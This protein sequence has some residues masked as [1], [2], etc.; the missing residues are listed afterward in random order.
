MRF[1]PRPIQSLELRSGVPAQV[2]VLLLP[3]GTVFNETDTTS[4]R[5]DR[6]G[7]EVRSPDGVKSVLATHSLVDTNEDGH[8]AWRFISVK[9]CLNELPVGDHPSTTTKAHPK[10]TEHLPGNHGRAEGEADE[11][12]FVLNAAEDTAEPSSSSSIA[13]SGTMAGSR[14]C[15]RRSQ[16]RARGGRGLR[17]KELY[18]VFGEQSDD[19]DE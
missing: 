1:A 16:T 4:I 5:H 8:H 11:P 18:D 17:R 14:I 6:R 10:H 19:E 15:P 12:S 2:E 9:H 13:P 3:L 7:D